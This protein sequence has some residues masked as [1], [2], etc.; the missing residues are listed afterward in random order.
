MKGKEGGKGKSQLHA[1]SADASWQ[2]VVNSTTDKEVWQAS[3]PGHLRIH[4]AL[5][6]L[7]TASPLPMQLT[8]HHAMAHRETLR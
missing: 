1:C 5:C 2:E 6:C 8:P 3:V 4:P 7:P